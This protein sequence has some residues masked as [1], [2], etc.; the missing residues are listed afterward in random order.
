MEGDI[1]GICCTD[2]PE[3]ILLLITRC[4]ETCETHENVPQQ[5]VSSLYI[6]VGR[7][8]C[9]DGKVSC[10]HHLVGSHLPHLATE[11]WKCGYCN[12]EL[13]YHLTI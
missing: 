4:A 11:Q 3:R 9:N 6:S 8:S 5:P 7:I 12:K 13:N 2:T 1:I 10:L